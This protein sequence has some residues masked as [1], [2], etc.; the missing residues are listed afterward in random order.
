[1]CGGH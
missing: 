1:M